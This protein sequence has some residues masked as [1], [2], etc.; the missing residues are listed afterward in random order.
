MSAPF[1]ALPT[2][3]PVASDVKRKRVLLLDTSHT[4]RDLR[5]EALR[6]LGMDVDCAADIPEARSWWRPALYDLVLVHM[7]KGQGQ[8][9]SFCD[10]LRSA[11]PSQRLAFLVGQ[12]QYLAGSP[13]N[14]EL[15]TKDAGE[16]PAKSEA[17]GVVPAGPGGPVQRWGILEASRRISAA[18]SAAV[19]R[20]QAMRA[21]PPP[22]RDPEGRSSK[23]TA[24]ST[25]LQDLLNKEGL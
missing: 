9:D 25:S 8:R 2:A 10:D 13:S 16:L 21:M 18:R 3:V 20:T 22:P 12:P 14:E 15:A 19:A 1:F 5:A 6:K 17:K 11:V 24:I 23:S 7:E 4:K